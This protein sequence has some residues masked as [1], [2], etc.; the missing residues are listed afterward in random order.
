MVRPAS[1]ST[2]AQPKAVAVGGDSTVFVAEIDNVE[3]VRS[4]QKVFSI[5]LKYTPSAIAAAG[6]VVAVGGEV[7][8]VAPVR[9]ATWASC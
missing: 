8:T 9:V 7:R 4:N 5:P 1:F 2:A 3:A 6:S